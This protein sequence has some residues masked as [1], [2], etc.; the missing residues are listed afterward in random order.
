MRRLKSR[1]RSTSRY[2]ISDSLEEM[3]A[4][5]EV[6]SVKSEEFVR[7]KGR[8][9]RALS[10][11][12][13]KICPMSVCKPEVCCADIV[14]TEK[15]SKKKTLTGFIESSKEISIPR[16][17]VSPSGWQKWQQKI[18]EMKKGISEGTKVQKKRILLGEDASPDVLAE[19]V[20]EAKKH[21][22][23]WR[24][25]LV[26]GKSSFRRSLSMPLTRRLK[27]EK[28]SDK[29][30]HKTA[31]Q[32]ADVHELTNKISEKMISP[33]VESTTIEKTEDKK[34]EEEEFY[35]RISAYC[36]K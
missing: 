24:D 17:K 5:L 3:G 19:D 9:R 26:V 10:E 25:N 22:E 7:K 36:I 32:K 2:K 30:E 11:I 27:D 20:K 33:N 6:K 14:K 29:E 28:D 1:I 35:P 21:L 31:K 34:K 18:L 12:P 15:E 23:T 13:L 8:K 4:K 16:Q